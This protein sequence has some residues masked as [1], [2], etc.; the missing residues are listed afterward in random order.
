MPVPASLDSSRSPCVGSLLSPVITQSLDMHKEKVCFLSITT[1]RRSV[2]DNLRRWL[3]AVRPPMPPPR[4]RTVLLLMAVSLS[5]A[6]DSI[7]L[8][9]QAH[10]VIHGG[11]GTHRACVHLPEAEAG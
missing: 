4:T 11:H 2:G 1:M 3:A 10:Q 5:E 7:G 6:E 8:F 9:R